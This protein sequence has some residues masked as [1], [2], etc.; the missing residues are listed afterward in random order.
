MKTQNWKELELPLSDSVLKTIEK[1][2][3]PYM[4]PVQAASIPLLLKGKDV[5]AEAVTGSGKTIAFLVP[6]LEILQKRNEKWKPIEIGA[7]IISPT[8]ELAIQIN[9]VLQKFLDHIPDLKQVL[10]VGG[11]TIAE[12]A[13]R[14]K[15][16]ANI[17]VATPGRLEDML[18]NCKSINLTAYV[19]SL[20]VLILDEADRLLDLGFSATLDTILSYLPRL[21]RTGLFSATQTKE[22]QQ[23]IRA[24]L[25]NPALITVK[26]KPNISTPLNLINNYVIVNAEY[27]LSIMIDF[28]QRKGTNLKY[29]IFLST[30]ACVDYFSHVTQ[31]ML[32]TIQV[33]A[34][35]GK[36]KNKRYK[37]FNDF[38]S[39]ESGILI[40]TDVMARGIDIS[41]VDWVLQYDPP[42]SAS[43]F[44]H[45]CGRTARIGNEGNALLFLLKTEDAYVDFIKRNQKVDLQQIVLEP[46]IISYKKCLICMRNLQKQDRSLFD[47][48]NR[49]FVS[50]VQAYNK[51][52]C[53]LILRLKD[54]D[55]GKLAMGFGLLRMP[56]MPEL[57]GKDLS[58][59]QEEDTDINSITYSDKQKEKSRLEKLKIFRDTGVW[60]K[61]QK[62]KCKQTEPWSEN[63]KKKMEKQQNRK[64][65]KEKKMKQKMSENSTKKRKRK[66]NEQDIKDLAK[67]IALI[68][69]LKKKKISQ[70]EF[71][72]AFGTD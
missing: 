57:K 32:P 36:M 27:K 46:S 1:L 43:S 7:I 3:F 23:L 4:T 39:I 42:C 9:E 2:N 38:R 14:L 41:E 16:G 68:K 34:I 61:V 52:E 50:Y 35:H 28:I 20:E 22:L 59:F 58:N 67:D 40:C 44:V 25:R 6:L 29:M 37:V 31:T 21:R 60:P 62:R 55:L 69:K 30:C 26:E 65:R 18:S 47:K 54:I 11:T 64:K 49:A 71:D 56:R 24:G 48:A 10:L 12:D 5:A 53:N 45:R 70:E 17:I 63:K 33:F 15:A 13:D 72:I 8:R 19:K 66:I 51:H